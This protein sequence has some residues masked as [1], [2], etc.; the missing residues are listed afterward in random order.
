MKANGGRGQR[1]HTSV[2]YLVGNDKEG[3]DRRNGKRKIAKK[4][5]LFGDVNKVSMGRCQDGMAGYAKPNGEQRDFFTST[6]H[7]AIPS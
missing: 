6:T 4:K 2:S 1:M 3:I 5:M 7:P